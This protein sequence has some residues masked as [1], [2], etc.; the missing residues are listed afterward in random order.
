MAKVILY[1]F[2]ISVFPLFHLYAVNAP[3][4][5]PSELIAPAA[6]VLT[7]SFLLWHIIAL[8]IKDKDKAALILS[9]FLI[10]FWAYK[11]AFK[12]LVDWKIFNSNQKRQSFLL[13]LM[14]AAPL[15]LAIASIWVRRL[16]QWLRAFFNISAA[17]AVGWQ[18]LSAGYESASFYLTS[19]ETA[20]PAPLKIDKAKILERP[21][22]YYIILD[23]LGRPDILQ[24]I[25]NYDSSAFQSFL[26]EHGFFLASK[27]TAN[28]PQTILSLAAALTMQYM[29]QLSAVSLKR[30]RKRHFA[31]LHLKNNV[32]IN[33]LRALGYI[34]IYF[35]SGYSGTDAFRPDIKMSAGLLLSEFHNL[36]ISSSAIPALLARLPNSMA[37]DFQFNKHRRRLLYILRYL[38][39]TPAAGP[40]F[41]LAHIMAP[42]PPFVF[43]AAGNPIKLRPG[44][45]FNDGSHYTKR[46]LRAEYV[47]GYAG[48]VAFILKELELTVRRILEKSP[49]AVII[50]QGD[51]GPG[52]QLIWNNEKKTNLRER[53]SIFSAYRVPPGLK[54]KLYTTITPVNTFR[55]IFNHFFAT[56]LPLLKDENYFS[57]W[58]T[59][60]QFINVTAQ[61]AK[62]QDS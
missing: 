57:R 13:A 20:V 43:D 11:P 21:D 27:A 32:V 33:T 28:Y 37:A 45:S 19:S 1:P 6:V 38:H 56:G 5:S 7:A 3:Q 16:P 51:H 15:A 4:V 12:L 60:Y 24:E 22:I 40:K 30:D 48:Q 14:L 62:P 8:A 54:A 50:I 42:H 31:R 59:P 53:F 10:L 34:F 9:L 49:D 25:Y 46:R 18:L 52:S 29:D 58:V 47:Q 44:F 26:E 35:S 41:V 17:I 61:V 23:G 39:Q 36:L 55:L 2:L